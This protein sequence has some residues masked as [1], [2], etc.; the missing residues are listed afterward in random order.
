MNYR[1]EIDTL[2][3]GLGAV[4]ASRDQLTGMDLEA[5]I[6]GFTA[7][8]QLLRQ[9][10]VDLVGTGPLA[11]RDL[12]ALER[13]PVGVLG[14][15]LQDIPALPQ[16]AMTDIQST[17]ALNET[18][19]HW[20]VVARAA[21]LAHH[22]WTTALPSSRPTG[23]TVQAELVVHARIA[24]ALAVTGPALAHDLRAAGRTT[25][26]ARL[27][28]ATTSGLR[29][30]AAAARHAAQLGAAPQLAELT[31]PAPAIVLAVRRASHVPAALARLA[32]LVEGARHLTPQHLQLVARVGAETAHTAAT[33]LRA[34]DHPQPAAVLD[35]HAELLAAVSSTGRRAAS[36]TPP[37]PRPLAQAQQIHDVLVAIRRGTGIEVQDAWR[38]GQAV[39]ALTHALDT[40]AARE[41]T[42]RAWLAPSQAED[43]TAL[44]WVPVDTH[45]P[46][47]PISDRIAAAA[48]H[49][50]QVG[51]A[52]ALGTAQG[53][54]A[55]PAVRQAV[56]PTAAATRSL[57]PAAIRRNGSHRR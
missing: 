14:R 36:I 7:T 25:D 37:D 22:D 45:G 21:V 55:A 5:G 42:R 9:V 2:A 27:L 43:L 26:A 31:Q 32:S 17:P 23:P 57:V 51:S 4:L 41:I 38:I 40:A 33:V 8:A 44:A 47:L 28:S 15:L 34:H 52:L 16:V 53:P 3:R 50:D 1:Q 48:T 56:I 6:T 12:S 20:R 24:E 49:A 30:T 54:A 29:I 46:R 35:R 18:G 19:A 39:P 10:H 13:N 11:P